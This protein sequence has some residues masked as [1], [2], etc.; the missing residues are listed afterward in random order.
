MPAPRITALSIGG[1]VTA[2]GKEGYQPGAA[3]RLRNVRFVGKNRLRGMQIYS[4]PTAGGGNGNRIAQTIELKSNKFATIVETGGGSIVYGNNDTSKIY[5]VPSYCTPFGY[6]FSRTGYLSPMILRDRVLIQ[7]TFGVWANDYSDPDLTDAAQRVWR[8]AGLPQPQIASITEAAGSTIPDA[9]MVSYGCMFRRVYQDGYELRSPTSVVQLKLNDSGA[10]VDNTLRISWA[11]TDDITAGDYVEVYRSI[12]LNPAT[13]YSSAF[14]TGSTLF[15]VAKAVLTSTDASNKFVDVTDLQQMT[16]PDF[17]TSG[18]EMYT[19][20]TAEGPTQADNQPP[21]C[22]VQCSWKGQAFYGNFTDSP[23]VTLQAKATVGL[24]V[25]TWEVANGIG[26]RLTDGTVTMGSPNVTGITPAMM[27]GIKVG[28]YFMGDPTY[29]PTTTRVIAASG[30][31]ITLSTNALSSGSGL[32][33]ADSISLDGTLYRCASLGD[34]V[35]NVGASGLY[36]ITTSETVYGEPV[37]SS[38]GNQQGVAVTIRPIHYRP[39]MLVKATNGANYIGAIPEATATAQTIT[40]KSQPNLIRYS[41]TNLPEAVPYDN[42]IPAALGALIALIPTTNYIYAFCTDGC[43][44]ITGVE[45]NFR[46]DALDQSLILASPKAASAMNE[47]VFCITNRG[48]LRASVESGIETISKG[49]F[50]SLTPGL[51]FRADRSPWLQ[52]D[53]SKEEC[54]ILYPST[55]GATIY[56]WSNRFVGLTEILVTGSQGFITCI[57]INSGTEFLLPSI[58]TGIYGS[59]T[60]APKYAVWDNLTGSPLPIEVFLRELGDANTVKQWVDYTCMFDLPSVG[61]SVIPLVTFPDAPIST[62]TPT[63]ATRIDSRVNFGIPRADAVRGEI[64]VGFKISAP[65]RVLDIL[66]LS[67][68]VVPKTSQSEVRE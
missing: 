52:C 23:T 46:V 13:E 9:T 65:T 27:V 48:F 51:A 56:L 5:T 8:S 10:A 54:W 64:Q 43:Y 49:L 58:T 3:S 61:N 36:E 62:G 26:V 25:T 22:L 24:L 37:L 45:G 6:Y 1:L 16:A 7:S 44:V 32:S 60:T 30:T 55:T 4:S 18:A 17:A 34:L 40:G 33:L 67:L 63:V 12:G 35:Q 41:K 57:A 28:Q 31:T 68:R 66:G 21:T 53:A 11:Y 29:F 59:P 15:L 38:T 39:S 50:D 14:D 42:E 19:S 47:K 20:P 2:P